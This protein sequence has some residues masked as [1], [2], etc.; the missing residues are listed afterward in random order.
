MSNCPDKGECELGYTGCFIE[1]VI[2]TPMQRML[3]IIPQKDRKSS[4]YLG[5]ARDTY[6]YIYAFQSSIC[7]HHH[8]AHVT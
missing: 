1:S 7:P 3:T 8:N 6:G 2:K 4:P 5:Y